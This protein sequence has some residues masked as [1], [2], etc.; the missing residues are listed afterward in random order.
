MGFRQNGNFSLKLHNKLLLNYF[1]VDKKS[2]VFDRYIIF[3]RTLLLQGCINRSRNVGLRLSLIHN[4]PCVF[5]DHACVTVLP[6]LARVA[7]RRVIASA[8]LDIRPEYISSSISVFIFQRNGM[9]V[10]VSINISSVISCRFVTCMSISDELYLIY[11]M[12]HLSHPYR[13][14]L[15]F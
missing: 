2:L 12:Y 7:D 14:I 15:N 4:W 3:D 10:Y 6:V 8:T 1:Q 9:N 11:N 13:F 5:G